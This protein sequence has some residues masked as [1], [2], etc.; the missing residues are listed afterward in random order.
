MEPRK[1]VLR[2]A[3]GRV[4]KGFTLDFSPDKS[5]FHFF[6]VETQPS[7]KAL[8]VTMDELKAIFFVRDF[9][10]RPQYEERKHFVEGQRSP[11]RRIEVTFVDGEALVGYTVS[12][13]T[14][15]LGF[16]LFPADPQSNNLSAFVPFAAAQKVRQL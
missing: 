7:G 2:Y 9:A 3:D 1:V 14:R 15:R 12:Y 6:A 8:E 10:G 4:V 11:G 5:R 16:I 13:D